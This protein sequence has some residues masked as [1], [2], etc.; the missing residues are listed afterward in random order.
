VEGCGRTLDSPGNYECLGLRM[1]CYADGNAYVTW[2]HTPLNVSVCSVNRVTADGNTPW[3]FNG[4]NAPASGGAKTIVVAGDGGAYLT[5]RVAAQSRLRTNRI[6]ADGTW[7]FSETVLL[8]PEPGT[9][10]TEFEMVADGDKGAVISW[11]MF[12]ST[13]DLY[14]TSLDSTG[15]PKWGPAVKPICQAPG[16]QSEF[17][18]QRDE[19]HLFAVWRDGRTGAQGIY[20]QKFDMAGDPLWTTDGVQLIGTEGS[21]NTPNMA[22]MLDGGIM[23]TVTEFGYRGYRVAPDGSMAWSSHVQVAGPVTQLDRSVMATSENDAVS[24]WQHS[25]SVFGARILATGALAGAV[26]IDEQWRTSPLHTW[27]VPSADVLY[28]RLPTAHSVV[29]IPVFNVDG[30]MVPVPFTRVGD[31]VLQLDLTTL[32]P[33]VYVAQVLVDAKRHHARFV[34]E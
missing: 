32:S 8:P 10:V 5:W 12:D 15:V 2:T 3:G 13:N 23:V 20:A 30:R 22:P 27:P 29:A 4:I 34:K 9:Q 16:T 6:R 11:R 28:M 24:F 18:F 14:M 21:T 33:G 1:A 19:D 31:D 26:G 17:R 7:A 25:A